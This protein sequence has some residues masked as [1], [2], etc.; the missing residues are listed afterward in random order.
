MQLLKRSLHVL[1]VQ[2]TILVAQ[3]HAGGLLGLKLIDDA[4]IGIA[5]RRCDQLLEAFAGLRDH[6][7]GGFHPGL[8]SA[9][10]EPRHLGAV[11]RIRL[12]QMGQQQNI[13]DVED[14]HIELVP[15]DVLLAVVGVRTG[16]LEEG[17]LLCA[18]IRHDGCERRAAVALHHGQVDI[19][20]SLRDS[21][22][23]ITGIPKGSHSL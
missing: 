20:I 13:A 9:I 5:Q 11:L 4:V 8:L 14:V 21:C 16:V 18:V 10:E 22:T 2:C 12:V 23:Y 19:R 15:V 3:A 6:V 1:H 17:A 7:D